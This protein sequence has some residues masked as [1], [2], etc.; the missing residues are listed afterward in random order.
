MEKNTFSPFYRCVVVHHQW[1]CY[2]SP[3]ELFVN[4]KR[5]PHSTPLQGMSVMC[6]MYN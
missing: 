3:V 2:S 6:I 1:Y 5:G 4:T